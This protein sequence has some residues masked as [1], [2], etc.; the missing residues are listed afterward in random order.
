MEA[1][2][3]YVLINTLDMFCPHHINPEAEVIWVKQGTVKVVCD[4]HELSLQPGEMTLI[5]PYHLHSFIPAEGAEAV[6][7]M[8]PQTVHQDLPESIPDSEDY[9]ICAMEPPVVRFIEYLLTQMREG[10]TLLQAKGLFYAFCNAYLQGTQVIK[11]GNKKQDFAPEA[12]RYIFD[13]L[14]EDVDIGKIARH[15]GWDPRKLSSSFREQYGIKLTELTNNIRV[16]RAITLLETS[17][18][19]ISEV[20]SACGF[21][22]LRNFNRIFQMRL[23][24]TPSEYRQR[25]KEN[26]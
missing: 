12:L 1:Y 21:G 19:T 7:Y 24:C 18:M 25:L 11:T 10:Q 23:S 16:E 3:S 17:D 15:L 20:A 26:R 13:H 5:F 2:K 4:T 6:V 22:S 9:R 14:E 8:F